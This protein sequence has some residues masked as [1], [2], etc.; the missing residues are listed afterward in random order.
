MRFGLWLFRV[1]E[2]QSVLKLPEFL[3]SCLEVDSV[4]WTLRSGR[5]QSEWLNWSEASIDGSRSN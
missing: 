5:S 3:V 1:S 2:A 4:Y